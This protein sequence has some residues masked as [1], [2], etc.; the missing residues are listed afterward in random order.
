MLFFANREVCVFPLTTLWLILTSV[1]GGKTWILENSFTLHFSKP[2]AWT[3]S[4]LKKSPF[5]FLSGGEVKVNI[6]CDSLGKDSLVGVFYVLLFW[7][8]A[9][10]LQSLSLSC[11]RLYLQSVIIWFNKS[12]SKADP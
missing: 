5:G 7:P 1:N 6:I 9:D 10:L 4:G 3:F 8:G 12:P 11:F 2:G